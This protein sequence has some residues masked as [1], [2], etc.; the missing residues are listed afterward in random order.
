M[1]WTKAVHGSLAGVALLLA[2]PD[3]A[4]ED[5]AVKVSGKSGCHWSSSWAPAELSRGARL[6][7]PKKTRDVPIRWPQDP[8]GASFRRQGKGLPIA[9]LVVDQQGTVAD[10][11]LLRRA[12]WDPPWPEADAAML[13]A[14]RQWEFKPATVSGTP[15]Q[16]CVTVSIDIH[17]R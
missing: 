15:V 14:V 17:W 5:S 11:Q 4:A 2:P 9:E 10:A 13:Q 7:P 1:S 16:A 3:L 8:L 6:I 12:R